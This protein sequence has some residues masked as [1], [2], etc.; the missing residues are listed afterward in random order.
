MSENL[1]PGRNAHFYL[2]G[3]VGVI[4]SPIAIASTALAAVVLREIGRESDIHVMPLLK[5]ELGLQFLG[6]CVFSYFIM[7]ASW[8]PAAPFCFV[9][10][11]ASVNWQ[12]VAMAFEV[13]TVFFPLLFLEN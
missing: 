5:A 7:L 4:F 2:Q 8:L 12:V 9:S 1:R 3:F 13:C 6:F 11:L 10:P